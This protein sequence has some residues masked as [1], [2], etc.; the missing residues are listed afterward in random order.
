MLT[1][2]VPQDQGLLAA[3]G[4]VALRH[5]HMIHILKMTIKTLANLTPG[6]ALA[7]TEY[8]GSSRLRT[9]IGKLARK[10]LGEGTPLLK[11]QALLN[12]S[13]RLTERRNQL[14]HSLWAQELDGE[15]QLRDAHG[16]TQ[17][18][19]S[20]EQLKNLA[21]EIESLTTELNHERLDGFLKAALEERAT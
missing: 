21:Q 8:E 3:F 16:S 7:A 10:R 1:F 14:V 4:E 19:P 13:K 6:E 20:V 12:R 18:L 9:R 17:P 15:A 11:L 5:E 2:H